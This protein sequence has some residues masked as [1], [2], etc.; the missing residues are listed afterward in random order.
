M[1]YSILILFTILALASCNVDVPN[2]FKPSNE[3]VKISPDY[4]DLTI[5]CNIAPLN[6][7]I[8]ANADDYITRIF[9]KRNTSGITLKGKDVIIDTKKWKGL[10]ANNKADSVFFEVFL[11]KNDEWIKYLPI[12]NCVAEETID[13]YI[14]YRL[15]QPLFVTYYNL[16]ILQRDITNFKEKTIFDTRM[17]LAETHG[18]CVN[19]HS[20]QDYNQ[21]G[22]MQFHVRGYMGGTIIAKDNEIEK[23]NL[24]TDSTLSAGVYPAWHPQLDL[25][26][27]SVNKIHQN[28]HTK[29]TQKTEVQ[30]TKSGIILY[31]VAKNQV[32]KI[33]DDPDKLETFPYWAP[34]GKTLFFASTDYTPTMNDLALEVTQNYEHIKY[35]LYSIPFNPQTQEF[36]EIDTVFDASAIGKSA[37]FP[38]LSPKGKYLMFT[39]GDYGNFHIW[40]KSSDL[41][42]R[43]METGET[44]NISEINSDDT[45]SYHSWS[46]NG[47]W[48]IFSS[49]RKNGGYTRFYIAYFDGKGNFGKP[50]ILPQ[51]DPQFYQQFF[52]SYNIPEF[53]VKPVEFTPHELLD[54][55]KTESKQAV[56]EE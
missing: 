30:D 17:T 33:I 29:D 43:N 22:K 8:E 41:Y 3:P 55:I 20:F 19:C 7:T 10:I 15:I 2:N 56:Y 5:P 16:S 32:R 12:K 9:T 51:K 24:K 31:D 48:V 37:T 46:S 25:I 38:R 47:S 49:R 28:F 27:Y 36:G 21:T 1:K 26:A 4:S 40:H 11:K 42:L 35:N 50:F 13:Q 54:A 23:I 18:Q 34:D 39:L 52:K 44:R 45:E 14:T 6:F 53:L